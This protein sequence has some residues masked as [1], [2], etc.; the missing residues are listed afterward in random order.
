[1]ILINILKNNHNKLNPRNLRE[2]VAPLNDKLNKICNNSMEMKN[3]E[4]IPLMIV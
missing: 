4:K 3:E 1:L 2:I